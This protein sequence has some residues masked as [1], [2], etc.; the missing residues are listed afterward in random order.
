VE[1]DRRS[2][3]LLR[4]SLCG[5]AAAL[6]GAG[7]ATTQGRTRSSVSGPVSMIFFRT[8]IVGVLGYVA[9]RKTLRQA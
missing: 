3:S 6:A 1:H 7:S 9:R 4:R 2:K 8:G 5:S